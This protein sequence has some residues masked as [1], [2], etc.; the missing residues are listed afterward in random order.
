MPHLPGHFPNFFTSSERQVAKTV[1]EAQLAERLGH[2]EMFFFRA[3]QQ[4]QG[5]MVEI[6]VHKSPWVILGY[7]SLLLVSHLVGLQAPLPSFFLLP[8]SLP[9]P[10]FSRIVHKEPVSHIF[11]PDLP[12]VHRGPPFH[13]RTPMEVCPYT[14]TLLFMR[15]TQDLLCIFL[16]YLPVILW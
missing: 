10:L 2:W 7:K 1:S 9:S 12:G 6:L 13:N 16:P 8:G 4:K 5:R 11:N 14:K 3:A 15:R